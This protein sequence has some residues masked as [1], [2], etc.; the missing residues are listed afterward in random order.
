MPSTKKLF[1]KLSLVSFFLLLILYSVLT[2]SLTDPNLVLIQWQ[3]YWQFQILMWKNF[4]LNRR[5]LTYAYAL[6]VNLLFF[7]YFL[8]IKKIKE[9]REEKELYRLDKP[10]RKKS[11][12]LL[13]RSMLNN[14]KK[15]ILYFLLLISPLIFSYNALSHDVFN[16][17]FNAKMVLIYKANPHQQVALDFAH[18]P[19]T[20][21][22]HN[23]HTPAPYA[24]GWTIFSLLPYLLGFNKFLSTWLLFRLL[25]ILSIILLFIT[26]LYLKK[27]KINQNNFYN[28]ALL[29]LNPLL[30]VELISNSHNDLWMMLP[31]MLALGLIFKKKTKKTILLS[32]LL[33]LFSIS[34]KYASAVLLP[35]WLHFLLKKNSVYKR[36]QKNIK[37]ILVKTKL[38]KLAAFLS[39]DKINWQTIASLLFFIPLFTSRSQQFHPWY[40]TWILVW[41]P[42]IK[43]SSWKRTILIFSYTSMLRYVPWIYAG[44]FNDAII[45]RQKMITWIVPVI[46]LLFKGLKKYYLFSSRGSA[47]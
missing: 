21:F 12:K 1:F 41:L 6:I 25:S 3:P 33:L 29:F 43:Q 34:S 8:I 19:W 26:V 28:Y 20:R 7:N 4:F 42:W 15:L 46:Y 17:I 30:L 23:T 37:K 2:Y 45:F 18:D 35:I 24:Y 11:T 27:E 39:I 5:L 44:G 14:K 36:L 22:M 32:F 10:D 47:S 38:K 40:L 9:E 13:S 16:Y 31:A